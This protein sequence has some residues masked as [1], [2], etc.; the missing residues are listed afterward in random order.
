MF[1]TSVMVEI[2]EVFDVVMRT[3]ILD[4]LFDTHMYQSSR[5]HISNCLQHYNGMQNF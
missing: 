4:V 2:N 5:I 3:H 1:L